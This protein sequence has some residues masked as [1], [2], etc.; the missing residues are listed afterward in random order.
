MAMSTLQYATKAIESVEPTNSE[1]YLNFGQLFSRICGRNPN[2]LQETYKM[3]EKAYKLS[4]GNAEYITE[5][6]YQSVLQK[7]YKEAQKFF[8]SATKVDDSS[9]YA[10]CGLTLCQLVESGPSEQVRQQIEFLS[11][12]QGENK[13]P[14]LLLMTARLNH[15][16]P[17]VAVSSLIEAAEIQFKNLK[18]LSYGPEYLRKFNPDFLLEIVKELIQHSPIDRSLS[19]DALGS[20]DALHI[21]LKHSA[22]ILDA[23]V[24][25]CPGMIEGMFLLARVQFLSNEVGPAALTLQQVLEIDPTYSEAHLLI[26]NIHIQQQSYQRASQSLEICLSHNFKV[27]EY[28]IYHLLQGIV[29]KSQQ[30]YDD[31][32]K[33]FSS[34]MGLIGVNHLQKSPKKIILANKNATLSLADRLTLYLETVNTYTHMNQTQEAQKLMQIINQEFANTAEEGRLTIANSDFYLQQGNVAKAIEMLRNIQPNQTYYVPVRC[35]NFLFS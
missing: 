7:K 34:A 32:L 14:L 12:I 13:V 33:S 25:A 27:R 9:V 18:T 35:Y 29:L 24:K 8:K 2:V 28:P 30:H 10:L 17:D 11:E 23:I 21:T 5:L 16:K 26:A 3:V 4:P 19:S 22:N 31:A 20:R 15:D 1:L 6:G